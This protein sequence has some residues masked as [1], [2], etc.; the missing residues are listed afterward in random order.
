VSDAYREAALS[1]SYYFLANWRWFEVVGLIAPLVLMAFAA[2]ICGLRSTVGKLCAASVLVGSAACLSSLLFV[3]PSHP[4]LLM[5]LQVLRSFHIIYAIGLI[6]IGGFVLHLFKGRSAFI[7]AA[8]FL[9]ALAATCYGDHLAYRASALIEWP[10]KPPA[11]PWEQ[12]FLWIRTHTPQNAVFAAD[13]SAL[14]SKGED[15]QGFRALSERS[16]LNDNKDEG[17]ASLFPAD[18]AVWRK[19]RNAELGLNQENDQERMER[20]RPYGVTWILLPPAAR[21]SLN[22]PY[23]NSVVAVCRLSSQD[24]TNEAF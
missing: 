12:A 1:R 13:A 9:A 20:L 17:V 24:R 21:T 19:R 10:G 22:C 23:R 15:E 14:D 7:A 3:H 18:A 8:L 6:M 4:D 2:K 16:T 11:N 5:R